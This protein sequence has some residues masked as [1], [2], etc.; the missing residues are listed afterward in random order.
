M[1]RRRRA[2]NKYRPS[3]QEKYDEAQGFREPA[4]QKVE[5]MTKRE[6]EERAT[7]QRRAWRADRQSASS[8]R[9]DASKLNQHPSKTSLDSTN[10]NKFIVPQEAPRL[11]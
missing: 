7:S 6:V 5:I 2:R 11:P 9:H 4:E 1:I 10:L 3:L 8:A